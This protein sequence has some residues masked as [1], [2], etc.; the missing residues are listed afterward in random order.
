[1]GIWDRSGPRQFSKGIGWILGRDIKF[2]V[3]NPNIL[4]QYSHKS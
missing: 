2:E 1:M 4:Y 3:W